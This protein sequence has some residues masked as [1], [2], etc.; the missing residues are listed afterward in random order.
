MVFGTYYQYVYAV[1]QRLDM[2]WKYEYQSA[3]KKMNKVSLWS[4]L[5]AHILLQNNS[6]EQVH[7][8]VEILLLYQKNVNIII[9]WGTLIKSH[10]V[11]S[12]VSAVL[13]I[14]EVNCPLLN[15]NLVVTPLEKW[16]R[17]HT[18]RGWHDRKFSSY[19]IVIIF[20]VAHTMF[21]I[22]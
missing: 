1:V 22:Y 13:F 15:R 18:F 4:C 3:V 12:L 6:L 21:W 20:Q 10:L 9:P 17:F 5:H 19:E 16:W 8:E 14:D 11:V 2:N 7:F